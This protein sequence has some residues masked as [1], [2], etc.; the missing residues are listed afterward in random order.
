MS[1][2]RLYLT[3]LSYIDPKLIST[4]LDGTDLVT[5]YTFNP[6]PP[7]GAMPTCLIKCSDGNYYGTVRK[8]GQNGKGY[9]FTM[10]PNG[11]GF[12]A[13]LNFGNLDVDFDYAVFFEGSDGRLYFGAKRYVADN[14]G[15]QR[16]VYELY[17]IHKNGNDLTTV[18]TSYGAA[19]TCIESSNGKLNW[20]DEFYLSRMNKDNTGK[21]IKWKHFYSGADEYNEIGRL[22]KLPNGDLFGG[23]DYYFDDLCST[24]SYDNWLSFFLH[25]NDDITIVTHDMKSSGYVPSSNGKVQRFD[26]VLEP[27]A[28]YPTETGYSV[29]TPSLLGNSQLVAQQFGTNNLLWGQ[30]AYNDGRF[31]IIAVN[32]VSKDCSFTIPWKEEIGYHG[33]FAF[34]INNGSPSTPTNE[35]T[36]EGFLKVSPNPTYYSISV[37]RSNLEGRIHWQLLDLTGKVVSAGTSIAPTFEVSLSA[38]PAGIYQL[39]GVEENAGRNFAQKVVKQ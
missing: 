19:T 33:R 37:E 26:S 22:S 9:I 31:D 29:C 17:S 8:G 36:M 1:D 38:L 3:L 11:G 15:N 5:N 13:I 39:V 21:E 35:V 7:D 14:W 10:H 6:L 27:A 32:T 34:E 16:A 20:I 23:V 12:N 18:F 30:R 24:Y 25:P 28:F 2:R 4:K